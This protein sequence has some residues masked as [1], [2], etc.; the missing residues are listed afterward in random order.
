MNVNKEELLH[1]A[2]LADLNISSEETENY[3]KNLQDILNYTEVLENTPV[4]ELA[5]TIGVNDN[6]NVFRKDEVVEF[7][8]K[9]MIMKNAPDIENNMYKIPKVLG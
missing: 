1:I 5:E 8:D 7:E 9:E 4:D 3:L 6:E 2:K